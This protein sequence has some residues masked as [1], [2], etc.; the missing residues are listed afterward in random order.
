MR[1][2]ARDDVGDA[3]FAAV[4]RELLVQDLQRYRLAGWQVLRR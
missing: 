3:V 1:A 4:E 2:A